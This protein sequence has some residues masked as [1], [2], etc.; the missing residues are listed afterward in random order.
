MNC[1][2]KS[3]RATLKRARLYQ[4]SKEARIRPIILSTYLVC[5]RPFPNPK[6]FHNCENLEGSLN[7]LILRLCFINFLKSC[8]FSWT[9]SKKE[10]RSAVQHRA[11][12]F[13]SNFETWS[14]SVREKDEWS[15]RSGF[16][17]KGSP[18]PCSSWLLGPISPWLMSKAKLWSGTPG[19]DISASEAIGIPLAATGNT[20]S[21]STLEEVM[22]SQLDWVM[23]KG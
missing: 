12:P 3:N 13:T 6:A 21:R 14:P 22:S 10:S 4:V 9:S 16:F 2:Q 1:P 5:A 7:P 18:S 20:C 19:K 15:A 17:T 8:G 11:K 23:Q